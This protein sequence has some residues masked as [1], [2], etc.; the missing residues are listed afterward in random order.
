VRTVRRGDLEFDVVDAGPSEGERVLLLHGF[1]QMASS[2]D[3]LVP[4]L[5]E[6]GYRTLAM[7]QRGYSP[8]A[9]PRGRRAY[10]LTELVDD[11]VAVIDAAGGDPV[12]VVAHDWGAVVGW[13]LAA[14]RPEKVRTFCA[15]SVPH[16][17]AFF[18]AMVTSRQGLASWYMYVLQLPWLPERLFDPRRPRGRARMVSFLRAFGQTEANA[19]RDAEQLADPGAYTAAI[20]WYR[21]MPLNVLQ[22][23]RLGAPVPVPTLLIWSDGDVAVRRKGVDLTPRLVTGPYRLEV[24]PGVSHW[25]PEEVP[26][27]VAQLIDAHI[28]EHRR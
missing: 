28:V 24:L 12:H 8:R 18:R 10:R 17:L 5:H 19:R 14:S 3:R 7:D 27:T 2:W 25:I 21:A 6:R 11:V 4:L 15:L 20:N 22:S 23:R 13:A 26:D 9:R 16:P 1:P